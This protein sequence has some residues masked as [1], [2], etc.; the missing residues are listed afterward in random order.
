[1]THSLARRKRDYWTVNGQLNFGFIPGGLTPVAK[2]PLPVRLQRGD[3]NAQWGHDHIVADHAHWIKTTGLSIPQLL[4]T[5]LAQ[6]GQAYTTEVDAKF[7]IK[8]NLTPNSLLLLKFT[9]G[10]DP[11][12]GVTSLYF[13]DS[14]I[15]GQRLGSYPGCNH[16][17]ALLAANP[18]FQLVEPVQPRVTTKKKRVWVPPSTADSE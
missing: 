7:K 6:P 4:L 10:S 17:R 2:A 18:T 8:L 11:F 15:D 16:A 9:P 1:M 3:A 14:H 13:R 5:K 12:F